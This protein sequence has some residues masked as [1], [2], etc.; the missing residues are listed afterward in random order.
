MALPIIKTPIYTLTLPS[1]GS[2]YEYRP[3]VV[4]EEKNLIVAMESQDS[5]IMINTLKEIVR[6]C[7]FDKA[8]VNKFTMFDLEF[9]FTRLRSVSSGS[10]ANLQAK[11]QAKECVG[12]H[13]IVV[14]LGKVEVV[15]EMVSVKERTIKLTDEGVGVVLK[16]PTIKDLTKYGVI[17]STGKDEMAMMILAIVSSIDSIYDADEVY[18]AEDSNKDELVAFVEQL[19]NTQLQK[20]AE[21]FKSI[22]SLKHVEEYDC[23]VCGHHNVVTLSGMQDFF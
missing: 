13:D 1:T 5:T 8:D 10:E 2:T 18:A 3:Y 16:Y 4:K 6:S 17:D 23:K 19:N 7:L 12:T 21:F 14:D 15:G 20:L 9:C 11:C 22:P